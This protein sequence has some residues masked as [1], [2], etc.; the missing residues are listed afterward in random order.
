MRRWRY[1]AS[2]RKSF[3]EGN[4]LL[5]WSW[6]KCVSSVSTLP[7]L[8]LLSFKRQ[9]HVVAVL[10][11][12]FNQAVNTQ[13]IKNHHTPCCRHN[14][15]YATWSTLFNVQFNTDMHLTQGNYWKS[16]FWLANHIYLYAGTINSTAS[17]MSLKLKQTNKLLL[18]SVDI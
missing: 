18:P 11:R 12:S 14:L 6:S 1:P 7:F 2:K 3:W 8:L 9:L 5:L 13:I 17:N 15:N 16:S 4:T 10:H